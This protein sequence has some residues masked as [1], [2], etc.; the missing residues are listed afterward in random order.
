MST[1][2]SQITGFSII[3]LIICFRHSKKKKSKLRATGLCDEI[4]PVSGDF[5]AQRASNAENVPNWGRHLALQQHLGNIWS[6]LRET[7]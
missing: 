2:A 5:P 4:S 3:Y 1:M 7:E 6:L